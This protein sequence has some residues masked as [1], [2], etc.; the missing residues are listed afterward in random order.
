MKCKQDANPD[1]AEN[2]K[3]AIYD[4]YRAYE[5]KEP[6]LSHDEDG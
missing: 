5:G 1:T 2:L 3:N 4:L 6:D